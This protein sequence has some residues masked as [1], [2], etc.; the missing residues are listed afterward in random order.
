MDNAQKTNSCINMPSSQ[1]FKSDF[2]QIW[3]W[4]VLLKF[5]GKFQFF[6][7]SDDNNGRYAWTYVSVRFSSTIR[8]IYT[9]LYERGMFRTQVT[10]HKKTLALW[11]A[12]YFRKS[13]GFHNNRT[14]I[15]FM[16]CHLI[17]RESL[18]WFL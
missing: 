14:K 16:L 3:Y 11:S 12:H 17:I 5:I 18:D 13:C 10:G 6:I 4:G 1:T 2:N 15:I 7:K 9:V 8:G